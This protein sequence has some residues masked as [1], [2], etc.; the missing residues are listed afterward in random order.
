MLSVYNIYLKYSTTVR[1]W[2]PSD[3]LVW[4]HE[5]LAL[6]LVWEIEIN[7]WCPGELVWSAGVG[8][9][10]KPSNSDSPGDMVE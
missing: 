6:W 9:H 1:M 10:I 4:E 8:D 7:V 5:S 2:F 3:W